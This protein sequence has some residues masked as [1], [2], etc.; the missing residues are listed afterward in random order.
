LEAEG[1]SLGSADTNSKGRRFKVLKAKDL[2]SKA[3]DTSLEGGDLGLDPVS[4][5]F[6]RRI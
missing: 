4:L 6:E 2:N 3:R 1:L 5:S